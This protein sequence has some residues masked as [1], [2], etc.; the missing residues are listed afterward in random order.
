MYDNEKIMKFLSESR[1]LSE[2]NKYEDVINTIK[3]NFKEYD[4]SRDDKCIILKDG[5]IQHNIYINP[6]FIEIFS[7]NNY[8]GRILPTQNSV[9][10]GKDKIY[11]T[12]IED[13][14]PKLSKEISRRDKI[15]KNNNLPKSANI[16]FNGW[17][18]A[19]GIG[20]I[21]SIK[22]HDGN[23]YIVKGVSP[24]GKE[25]VSNIKSDLGLGKNDL[26]MDYDEIINKWIKSGDAI[27]QI[28]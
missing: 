25:L 3:D 17:N 15:L 19:D 6:G 10:L 14:I 24:K 18:S 2:S 11:F 22:L 7:K 26:I 12:T 23:N 4:V 8:T 13:S 16:Y 27:I 28:A 5:D 21:L 1:N 20:T 9:M